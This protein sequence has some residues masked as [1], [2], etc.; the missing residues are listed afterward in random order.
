M[1]RTL[2]R[3][4]TLAAVLANFITA[5]TANATHS[6][7]GYH[8]ARSA[9]PFT[10]T[11]GNN[12]TPD[13]SPY[14][15]TGA[16]DWGVTSGRCNNP[17]NPVRGAVAAGGASS[18]NCRP[19]TGRVEVCNAS[20]GN[21]GWLGIAT[22]WVSGSHITKVSVK[23]NDYYMNSPPYNTTAWHSAVM[24]QEMGHTL[25][26]AHQDENFNNADLLDACGRGSCMD[27]SADPSNNTTPNQ[28]DYDELVIIYSHLDGAAAVSSPTAS[29]AA[30]DLDSPNGWGRAVSYANGR[31]VVF[32]QDLGGGNK[33]V[34]Y[35]LWAQ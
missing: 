21:N 4:C 22:I 5:G 34:T 25:G 18:R 1:S 2:G 32:E 14:L 35:V 15:V 31:P 13:W 3:L 24:D 33:M 19:P 6:W 7:N 9:N 29:E 12:L 10:V 27:Y 23:V 11:F 16:A 20:Y 8:W 28:H 17:S 30:G 26:L